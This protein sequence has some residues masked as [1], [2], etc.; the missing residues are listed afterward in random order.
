[1]RIDV[2]GEQPYE[3]PSDNPFV[4]IEGLDEIYAWGF[5]NPWKFSFDRNTNRLIVADVGQDNWEEIDIVEKGI[6]Y[7]WR[8]LEGN[9]PYDLDL[10]DILDIDIESLGKPIH[11]Y[12]HDIGKSITGGYIYRGSQNE[13]M[14]GN[15]KTPS[16]I[17]SLG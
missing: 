14:F 15:S 4:G 17:I 13:E 5:R 8:I 9:N 7:G 11:E 3:I 2:N 1:M 10:A 6:N 12:N 16:H